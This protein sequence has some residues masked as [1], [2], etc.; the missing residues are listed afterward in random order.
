V[1]GCYQVSTTIDSESAAGR[2]AEILVEERL[3]ACVQ[4]VGP[5]RSVYRW[6]GAVTQSTEWLC[7]AKTGEAG[8][9]A[10]LSRLRAVHSYQLPE[11]VAVPITGGDPGYLEWLRQESTPATE[12]P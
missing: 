5:L 9:P 2:I 11:I 1:S 6:E 10:L 8:L 3:A 7:V 12:L 4:V